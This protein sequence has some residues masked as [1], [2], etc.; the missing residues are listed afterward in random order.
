METKSH[1]QLH[2]F[3]FSYMVQG[4]LIPLINI[5]RLFASRGVKSTLIAT[6]L[7]AHLFSKAI[8]SSKKLGFECHQ[9]LN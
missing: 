2:I 1:K 9:V 3:F 5:A 4:H 8:Q 6:P 7:N